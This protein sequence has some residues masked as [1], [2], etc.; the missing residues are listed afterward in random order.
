MKAT[1]EQIAVVEKARNTLLRDSVKAVSLDAR[2]EMEELARGITAV[3]EELKA[4]D[5]WT[6]INSVEDLPPMERHRKVWFTYRDHASLN[7]LTLWDD[8]DKETLA[9]TY[10]AWMYYSEPQ[11]YQ[12]G[13][14]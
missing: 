9:K 8:L 6:A 12:Q 2:L 13:G 7:L 5:Q 1:P 3:L 14:E 4:R 10:S 11:P